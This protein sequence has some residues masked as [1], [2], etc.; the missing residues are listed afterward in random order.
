MGTSLFLT[1]FLQITKP[2]ESHL[3]SSTFNF[4]HNLVFSSRIFCG[5]CKGKKAKNGQ[6]WVNYDDI[7]SADQ[8]FAQE[9]A[10]NYVSN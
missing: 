7:T 4:L 5:N 8:C 6:N 9:Y 2:I 1:F 10:I 3:N